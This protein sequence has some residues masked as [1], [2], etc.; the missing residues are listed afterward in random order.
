MKK[1]LFSG[2]SLT[3]GVGLELEQMDPANYCN[4]F[5]R[6]AFDHGQ[7]D[8]IGLGGHSNLRIFLDTSRQLLS[9]EYNYAFVGW[10]SYPRHV[11]YPVVQPEHN[12]HWLI[13]NSPVCQEPFEDINLS[14]KELLLLRDKF[15]LLQHA[16][17]DIL[18]I[19][20]Y[21]NILVH[22]A[23]SVGT[24]IYFINNLCHWDQDYFKRAVE[25][26][27]V[28]DLTPHTRELIDVASR[29]D[30]M[31]VALYNQMHDEYEEHGGIQEQLW[32]N[33]YD[34]ISNKMVDIGNDNSH[35]G[36]AT[37]TKYGTLLAQRFSELN[38]SNTK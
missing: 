2:C 6:L 30:T 26:V 34:N 11:F 25:P 22:L 16:H 37:Y 8:N 19:V 12:R 27:K 18:D 13:P 20:R 28:S 15:L 1:L 9:G 36:T 5:S 31:I 29:R 33:L 17:Y 10:T 23:Q 24:K 14:E 3:Q 32:L 4:V 38:H 35:P 7:V 21:V